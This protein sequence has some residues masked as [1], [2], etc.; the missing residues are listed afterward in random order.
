MKSYEDCKACLS[1][2][3]QLPVEERDP[4]EGC[5]ERFASDSAER[6]R[7]SLDRYVEL[8]GSAAAPK[9]AV[10]NEFWQAWETIA[11]RDSRMGF[12]EHEGRPCFV[13]ETVEGVTLRSVIVTIT[14][15]GIEMAGRMNRRDH[16]TTIRFRDQRALEPDFLRSVE[17]WLFRSDATRFG[18]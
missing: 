5:A 14:D 12:F 3:G 11:T 1:S 7:K 2:Q 9:A 4:C 8:H 6:R 13:L 15:E 16:P 17:A 18:H 10:A